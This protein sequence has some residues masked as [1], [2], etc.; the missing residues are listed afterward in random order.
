M[1]VCFGKFFVPSHMYS[2]SY[3]ITSY[4]R[5]T[6]WKSVEDAISRLEDTLKWRREYGLYDRI[7]A[8]H[9]EP[10]V[11]FENRFHYLTRI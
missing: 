4:L 6:K 1:N 9:V 5:A 7:T 2:R 8:E 11:G 10:E 3:E